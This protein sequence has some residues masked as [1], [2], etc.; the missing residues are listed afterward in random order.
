MKVNIL[1]KN[2]EVTEGLRNAIEKK[3]SRLDK[4]FDSEQEAFVTLSVQKAR[5]IIEVTIRFNGVLLRSEEANSDMYAAID[6]VSDKLERQIV[7]HKSRLE[8]K[9]HSNVPLKYQ[10]IPIY[11]YSADEVKEPKIVKTKKFAIKPMS[12]EEAVLQMDLL[13]HDFFVYSNADTGDVNVVYKRKD[14]NYGLIEPEF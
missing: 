12:S 2:I 10:N 1:G 3:L 14:G 11:E 9:Y 4:F 13:G 8:R 5:K 6:I 7:K